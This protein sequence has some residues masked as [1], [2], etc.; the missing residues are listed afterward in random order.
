MNLTHA[1][2]TAQ[3]RGFVYNIQRS[4]YLRTSVMIGDVS[5]RTLHWSR[6]RF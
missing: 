5:L 6:L 3:Y 4:M 2:R 1:F